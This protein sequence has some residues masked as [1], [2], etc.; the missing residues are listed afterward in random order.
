MRYEK[1]KGTLTRRSRDVGGYIFFMGVYFCC[2]RFLFR[3]HGSVLGK[4]S[5]WAVSSMFIALAGH[6]VLRFTDFKL[7]NTNA[8]GTAMS[9]YNFVLGLQSLKTSKRMESTIIVKHVNTL[10]NVSFIFSAF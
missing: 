10:A 5:F 4:G 6:C 2:L 9:T 1:C 8:L 3:L 7:E